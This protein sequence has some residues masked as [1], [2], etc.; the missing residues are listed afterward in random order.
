[1]V[2]RRKIPLTSFSVSRSKKNP[3]HTRLLLVNAVVIHQSGRSATW[4]STAS[5]SRGIGV[6]VEKTVQDKQE[7]S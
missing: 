3:R 6:G 5:T 2:S 1:M 7:Y 4:A